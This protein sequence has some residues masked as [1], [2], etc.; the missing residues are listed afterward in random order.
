M[1]SVVYIHVRYSDSD[2][3]GVAH[4]GAA[5]RWFEVGRV[6]LMR[7]SGVSYRDVEETGFAFPVLEVRARYRKPARF[8]DRL[9]LETSYE[10]VTKTRVRFAYHL[11]NEE[12]E[13]VARGTTE[14]ACLDRDRRPCRIPPDMLERMDAALQDRCAC[15]AV[16]AH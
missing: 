10:T 7:A 16:E 12:G 8:G 15:T 4:H 11:A 6:E 1:T 9:K 2:K 5:I 14:H 13:T 3:M